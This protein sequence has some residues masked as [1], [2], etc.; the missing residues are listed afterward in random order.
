MKGV[1]ARNKRKESSESSWYGREED[2]REDQICM[3]KKMD[4]SSGGKYYGRV[5]RQVVCRMRSSRIEMSQGV[6]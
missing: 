5:R 4:R 1:K 3:W 6:K 2:P